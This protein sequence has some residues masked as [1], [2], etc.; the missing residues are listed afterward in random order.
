MV[1]QFSDYN[2][3]DNDKTNQKRIKTTKKQQQKKIIKR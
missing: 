2:Q 1:V 3:E